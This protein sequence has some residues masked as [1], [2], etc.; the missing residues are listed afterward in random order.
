MVLQAEDYALLLGSVALFVLLGLA[1]WATRHLG[2]SEATAPPL[3][4][5]A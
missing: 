5:T 4:S 1:M 3:G 2:T